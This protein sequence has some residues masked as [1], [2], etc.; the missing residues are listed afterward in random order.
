MEGHRDASHPDAVRRLDHC[1]VD[2]SMARPGALVPYRKDHQGAK[3][4]VA[5]M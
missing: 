4:I 1:W 2:N 5:R 3:D